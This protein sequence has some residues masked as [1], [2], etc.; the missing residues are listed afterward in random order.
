MSMFS[1]HKNIN[2]K[3]LRLQ[4]FSLKIQV[5]IGQPNT[6]KSCN[7]TIKTMWRWTMHTL[8]AQPSQTSGWAVRV[9]TTPTHRQHLVGPLSRIKDS[10]QWKAIAIYS[11]G[12]TI[13]HLLKSQLLSLKILEVR[14]RSL[15]SQH[16]GG[17]SI[18]SKECS[19][20]LVTGR[21]RQ[22]PL[23][24]VPD[25]GPHLMISLL[26]RLLR[27]WWCI[28]RWSNLLIL[29]QSFHQVQDHL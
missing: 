16:R 22:G 17:Y 14:Y 1:L 27:Q 25:R 19:R 4:Q 8:P 20:C 11:L 15:W 5:S 7:S 28:N 10:I 12:S 23:Y 13:T 3:R 9:A 24:L 21:L 29:G 18:Y 2:K 6:F 26:L